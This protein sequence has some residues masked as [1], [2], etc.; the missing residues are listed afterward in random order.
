MKPGELLVGKAPA[1]MHNAWDMASS[2]SFAAQI[3]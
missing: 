3:D 1:A 2:K